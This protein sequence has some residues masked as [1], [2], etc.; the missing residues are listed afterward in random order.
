MTNVIPFKKRRRKTFVVVTG[1]GI[2]FNTAAFS[3]GGAFRNVVKEIKNRQDGEPRFGDSL[4]K[5]LPSLNFV[6]LSGDGMTIKG[7][8]HGCTFHKSIRKTVVDIFA[9]N[10]PLAAYKSFLRSKGYRDQTVIMTFDTD[11]IA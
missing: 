5:S 4:R 10:L 3:A 2:R 8:G 9:K 6:V 7:T 1:C 11:H